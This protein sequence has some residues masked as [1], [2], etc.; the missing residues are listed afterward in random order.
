MS[1]TIGGLS[2]QLSEWRPA[3]V[4]ANHCAQLPGGR[5]SLDDAE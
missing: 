1:K 3:E 5:M 2:R 4:N